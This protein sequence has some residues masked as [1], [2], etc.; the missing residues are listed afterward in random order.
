[1][2]GIFELKDKF[3]KVFLI[4]LLITK[5]IIFQTLFFNLYSTPFDFFC[6]LL[7]AF[8]LCRWK[9]VVGKEKR[10]Q[11]PTGTPGEPP[12]WDVTLVWTLLSP[13]PQF[14]IPCLF[15]L[16]S[17][18]FVLASNSSR[19]S[20]PGLNAEWDQ[21]RYNCLRWQPRSQHLSF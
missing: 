4:W 12:L 7:V 5:G 21:V 8:L 13:V 14:G 11:E 6:T 20:E 16:S 9:L 3:I 18:L 1:V 15:S 19:M 2:F 17:S 10:G